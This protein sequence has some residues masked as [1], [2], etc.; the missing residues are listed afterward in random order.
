MCNNAGSKQRELHQLLVLQDYGIMYT[1][2]LALTWV[3]NKI[4]QDSSYLLSIWENLPHI[5]YTCLSSHQDLDR[6]YFIQCSQSVT[7]ANKYFLSL[8]HGISE[9]LISST[10][11]FLRFQ[12][13]LYFCITAKYIFIIVIFLYFPTICIQN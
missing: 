8:H 10:T 1:V 12:I 7:F 6:T 4:I 9:G 11:V 2:V 13:L 5:T 3:P